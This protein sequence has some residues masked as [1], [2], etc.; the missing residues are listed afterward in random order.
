MMDNKQVTNNY[1]I[2]ISPENENKIDEVVFDISAML[3]SNEKLSRAISAHLT[4]VLLQ[5][6]ERSTNPGKYCNN[7]KVSKETL[8]N[9]LFALNNFL[10]PLMTE[11][12]IPV[13]EDLD[14]YLKDYG[15]GHQ[16]N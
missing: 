12:G 6:Q 8:E 11:Y 13:M 10:V 1:N 2:K 9:R 14:A 5:I 7:T 4:L 3:K 16:R 15:N